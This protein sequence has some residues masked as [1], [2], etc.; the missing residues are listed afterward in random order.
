MGAL[1]PLISVKTLDS[2]ISEEL[3]LLSGE[4]YALCRTE[5]DAVARNLEAD[6]NMALELQQTTARF[7]IAGNGRARSHFPPG[8]RQC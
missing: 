3:V 7:K 6:L 5:N 8:Y 4:V 2:Q 1:L